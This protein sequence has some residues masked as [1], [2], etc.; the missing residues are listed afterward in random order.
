MVEQSANKTR[1]IG[2][3]PV[4]F[5]EDFIYLLYNKFR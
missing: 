4:T 2:S 3:N 5:I 1:I